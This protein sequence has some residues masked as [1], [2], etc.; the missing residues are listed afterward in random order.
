MNLKNNAFHETSILFGSNQSQEANNDDVKT[1][2][3][4][5]EPDINDLQFKT[6][7]D[8]G[9]PVTTEPLQ[10]HIRS[11]LKEIRK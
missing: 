3:E 2:E 1:I 11:A 6:L 4:K 8:R 10:N 5:R 7:E 9:R